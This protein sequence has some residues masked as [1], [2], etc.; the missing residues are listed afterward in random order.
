MLNSV[1]KV[2]QLAGL[3]YFYITGNTYIMITI[4]RYTI[5]DPL[6]AE[7]GF[8]I[9]R[10]VFVEEQGVLPDE[11]FE[12]EEES[13]HFLLF[14]F[15]IPV[16]TARWRATLDGIKLERFAVLPEY[17]GKG[18]GQVMVLSVLSDLKHR[19]EPI[20]LHSQ[21]KAIPLYERCGF[22][23][24]GPMFSECEILHYKMQYSESFRSSFS[25]VLF[26]V[27]DFH[28]AF[29]ISNAEKPVAKLPREDYELR[30]RLMQEE[31]EEYLKA[32]QTGDLNE[33]ADALG[34]QLY[35]LCGTILRHGL[36]EKILELFSEIHRSNM[37]KLD[38]NGKPLLREDGK[39]LK[40]AGYFRPDIAKILSAALKSHPER[41]ADK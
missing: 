34:D 26:K 24:T 41:P 30:H 6:L 27:A 20:Y 28:D 8:S 5:N 38:E 22:V 2:P 18:L 33:I 37:S 14:Y 25:E 19:K 29:G 9:R 11:E 4:K 32:C 1:W 31:N 12:S 15:D 21:L 40:G 35:I 36:Q 23:R 16:A 7:A 39:V 13:V 10:S 17:R 3:S